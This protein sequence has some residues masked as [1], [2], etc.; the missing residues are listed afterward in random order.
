MTFQIFQ[1]KFLVN[2]IYV[3]HQVMSQKKFLKKL[4]VKNIKFIGN[5]KFSQ[6]RK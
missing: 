2:L 4:G 1:K 5:L 3:F 6:I